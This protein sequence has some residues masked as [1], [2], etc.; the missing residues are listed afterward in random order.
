MLN[1]KYFILRGQDNTPSLRPNPAAYGNA[2]FVENIEMVNSNNEE[3]E[4]ID[5]ANLTE[6]V[7][8]HTEFSNEVSGFDPQK[9]GEIRLTSYAP[10]EL[11]YTSNAPSE[12]MAVF[13]E[14]W[15]G[16]NK[17][18]QAYIDGKEAPHVRANYVLRAMRVPAGQHE[19]RF[20]FNP[21]AY[22]TGEMISLISSLLILLGVLY[23][24]Y[25]WLTIP[26]PMLPV[27]VADIARVKKSISPKKKP[28]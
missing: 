9:S 28:R 11:V 10:D 17:G 2:W 3:F 18:W 26:P 27:P 7:F 4:A 5:S 23:A 21:T 12:Q 19:I 16:P 1:T 20:T 24:I 25:Y 8:I 14:I 22:R 13:S 6:T 15:Y